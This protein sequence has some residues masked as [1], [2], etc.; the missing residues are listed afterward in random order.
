MLEGWESP[1]VTVYL[2]AILGL[3][4]VWQYYQMQIMA[5]R[6]LAVD[7]FDRSSIRMYVYVIPDDDHICEVCSAAHGR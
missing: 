2:V 1:D 5:G 4:V 6:I 7:I 3:L